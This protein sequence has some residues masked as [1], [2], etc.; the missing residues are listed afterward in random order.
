MSVSKAINELR[1]LHHYK[2][3]TAPAAVSLGPELI[4]FFKQSVTKRQT[5]LV[6]IAECWSA[7]VPPLL[8]EHCALEGLSRGTLTVIVDTSSHLYE[9]KQVLLSGLERQLLLACKATGLR[10]IVLRHGRWY[11]GDGGDDRRVKFRR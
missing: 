2:S 7:L 3:K 10:K 8:S 4:D 1:Q 9:M 6:K 5:K 11:A